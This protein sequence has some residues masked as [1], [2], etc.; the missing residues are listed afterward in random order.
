MEKKETLKLSRDELRSDLKKNEFLVYMQP[1][2]DMV[3][4]RLHGAE[5]LSRWMHP[6]EGLLSPFA[7]I[8][9]FE[10]TGIIDELDLYVFEEACRIKAD[11]KKQGKKYADIT[12]S[13]NMSRVHLHNPD[14]PQTLSSIADKYEI[15]HDELEIEITETVFVADTETLI[16]SISNI[17]KQGFLIALDDFGSGFSGLN[18]LKD[19]TVD[20]IKI[21]K[22]FLHGSGSTE[23]GKIIIKNIN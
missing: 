7:F 19:I 21:D 18:L 22:S 15:S 5:A 16:Q 23:L 4:F 8:P 6:T 1:Q 10:E 3:T 12:I 14:F 11:W 17:K 13:V 2:I 9:Y 20:T